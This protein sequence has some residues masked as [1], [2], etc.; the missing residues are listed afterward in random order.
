MYKLYQLIQKYIPYLTKYSFFS[1][2]TLLPLDVFFLIYSDKER[3]QYQVGYKMPFIFK[4]FNNKTFFT[5]KKLPCGPQSQWVKY[6]KT[7][8]TSKHQTDVK[9][10]MSLTTFFVSVLSTLGQ[11]NL[12]HT[13]RPGG[14]GGHSPPEPPLQGLSS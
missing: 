13:I 7:V 12:P 2:S 6:I 3:E 4:Y 1:H 8:V 14:D 9:Q 5:I 10:V 11:F